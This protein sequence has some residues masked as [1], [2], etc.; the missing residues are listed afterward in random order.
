MRSR[1]VWL[2]APPRG[3]QEAAAVPP[4]PKILIESGDRL[5]IESGDFLLVEA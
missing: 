5:L 4:D 2:N 3:P 1:P